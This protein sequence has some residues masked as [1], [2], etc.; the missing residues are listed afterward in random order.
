MITSRIFKTTIVLLLVAMIISGCSAKPHVKEQPTA[1]PKPDVCLE[2]VLMNNNFT[3]YSSDYN[4]TWIHDKCGDVEYE[5]PSEWTVLDRDDYYSWV[6]YE[7]TNGDRLEVKSYNAGTATVHR[8]TIKELEYFNPQIS[9]YPNTHSAAFVPPLTEAPA[10]WRDEQIYAIIATT[11]YLE[12]NSYMV[13]YVTESRYS[14]HVVFTFISRGNDR[15]SDELI[16]AG[17]HF[18]NSL[19]DY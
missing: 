1:R 13:K 9:K 7:A 3:D 15:L 16:Y 2:E 12:D 6:E 8:M 4:F 14:D 18:F 17:K 11:D 19:N 5:I 10:I